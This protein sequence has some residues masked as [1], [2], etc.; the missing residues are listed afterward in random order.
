[1]KHAVLL[2]KHSKSTW[3]APPL[4]Q[5]GFAVR[6]YDQFDTDTLG[7]FCGT[8]ER[9]HDA[10]ATATHK[11]KLACELGGERYGLGSEGSFTQQIMSGF[12]W[13]QE[14]ICLYDSQNE[15][16]LLGFSESPAGVSSFTVNSVSDI[17][18]IAKTPIDQKW[19][20]EISGKGWVKGLDQNSLL[21]TIKRI[22]N[23]FPVLIVPDYRAM[24]C[25]SRQ[26][27]IS[28][29]ASDLANRLSSLCPK[30]DA[31][32]FVYDKVKPGL[33][34][35]ACGLP[36]QQALGWSAHCNECGFEAFKKSQQDTTD[37]QYCAF[38]NP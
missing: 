6:E 32:N 1:M 14:V 17:E 7:T 21:A 8:V 35:N 38:C 3:I 34:C 18:S 4:R 12:T 15:S 36:T 23:A 31:P 13:E 11:A 37:M 33:P 9:E 20:V 28:K 2:T 16:A 24:H 5:V 22:K 30:C 25:P 29:A 19:M 26:V 10:I 27:L